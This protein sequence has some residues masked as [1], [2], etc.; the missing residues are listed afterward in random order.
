VE[1]FQKMEVRDFHN[2]VI[3]AEV[4]RTDVDKHCRKIEPGGHPAAEDPGR[5]LSTSLPK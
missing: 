1:Y 3:L 2:D 5:G 4:C